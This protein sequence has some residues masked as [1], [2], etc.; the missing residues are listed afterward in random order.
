MGKRFIDRG[1]EQLPLLLLGGIS[2]A[3]LALIVFFGQAA[4]RALPNA[5]T[6]PGQEQTAVKASEAFRLALQPPEVRQELL[7][8]LIVPEQNTADT[9]LA[10]YLLAT[11]LLD[12]GQAAEI[13]R[14]SCRERV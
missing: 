6:N 14:A 11:D 2:L 4:R 7:Q 3:S 13:E 10:R 5:V 1:K 9:Y 12:Q 8:Q